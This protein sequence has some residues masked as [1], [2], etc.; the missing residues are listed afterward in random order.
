M[1]TRLEHTL[2][3]VYMNIDN[4]EESVSTI[5]DHVSL[6]LSDE[7]DYYNIFLI[8]YFPFIKSLLEPLNVPSKINP[9]I[10][11]PKGRRLR[12]FYFFFKFK[13]IL[14]KW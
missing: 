10:C 3:T 13:S 11:R 4:F 12:R 2:R 9:K 8:N 1:A 5:D 7:T 6:S 14:T